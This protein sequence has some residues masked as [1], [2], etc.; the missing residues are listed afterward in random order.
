MS[1]SSEIN[2]LN[3]SLKPWRDQID[4]IDQQILKLL[5]KRAGLAIEIGEIKHQQGSPI[6]K[7]EREQAVLQNLIA[8]NQGPIVNE[9]I[10][11]IWRE[12]M[13]ASRLLEQRQSV[14]FLGP[15]GTFS[16]MA[17]HKYFGHAALGEHQA[18]IDAVFQAINQKKVH[19]AVVPIENSTEGSVNRTLDLLIHTQAMIIGE[20]SIPVQHYLLYQQKELPKNTPDLIVCGHPQA[21]A[22]CQIYLQQHPIL[23]YCQRQA[24]ASNALAAE[25]AQSDPRYVAI[26]SEFCANAYALEIID[27]EIQDEFHNR[28]RFAVLGYHPSAPN[29][30]NPKQDQSSFILA[31]PNQAGA[32]LKVLQP[33]AHYG[34]S[35]CRLESRPAKKSF[36]WEYIFMIDVEGHIH[37]EDVKLALAEIEKHSE[38]FKFLGSYAKA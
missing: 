16:E 7:P 21:L 25:M 19:F 26:A 15:V 29:L 6:F 36:S 5:N 27:R 33:L 12:I 32:I 24:F 34:V 4:Q 23:Q 28:T 9:S 35:M 11:H 14:A 30:A 31:V 18:S 20:V 13:A 3:Q 22:Q 10:S 8:K 2:D 17:M 37:N 38:F 1:N